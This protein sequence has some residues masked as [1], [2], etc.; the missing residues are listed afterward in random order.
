MNLASSKRQWPL[1][2]GFER[3][4]GFLGGE[5][6]QWYPDLVYDNHPGRP[7]RRSPEEGYH[8]TVDLDRQGD[9]VHPGREG[10]RAGQA[11]LP[12]LLPRR[13]ARAAPRRRRSGPTSTR[14]SSTWATRP[15]ASRSSSAR[16]SSG[17]AARGHRALADQPVRRRRRATTASPGRSST[18]CARGTRS[19]TTRSGCSRG[20]RRCTRASSSH[21]DHEIGRLLDYLEESG[22]LDNTIIVLVSDNGASGEGG[23]NGSV[24]ENK[25]FN[26]VPDTIEENLKHARRARQPEDVQPLPDRLGVGVQH[27]VQDVE[28]LRELRGRHRRPADRLLADGDQGRA[29]SCA[30]ST[31]HAIDIVPTLLRVPRRRAA[32]RRQR[33]HAEAARGRQLRA[34]A[35]TTPTRR[36]RRRR[37]STRCSARGRSGTRAGR[38][39]PRSRPRPSRGATSTSSAGS[40]STPRPTRASATTSPTQHPEKL[41]ELIALWWAEAGK[42]QALP[43]ESRGAI[44]ILGAERPQLSKPRDRYVYYPGGAEVPESVAPNIRNRSYTIAAECEIETPEAGGVIFSQG[45]RFGG[46]ALYV[47]DGKLKYVYNW[48]GE[49][50]QIVESDEPIPTGHVVLSASFEREDDAMPTQ[51]TLSLHIRDEKVGEADDHD[52]AR[53]VRARRRRPRRRTVRGRAGHR[54]LRRRARPGRS[55]AARSSASSSTSAASRSSTSPRRRGRRSRGS[56]TRMSILLAAVIVVVVAAAGH[57]G[58]AARPPARSRGQ[59]LRRRRPRRGRVRRARHR[60]SR[61]CSGF[62]VFLAFESYDTSRSRRRDRG[63]DRRAAVRDRPV[64]ARRRARRR[65]RTSSSA[66]RATVVHQEWP[67]MADGHPRRRDQPVGRRDCSGRCKAIEPQLGLRAGGLRQVARPAR[68]PREARARPHPR[69]RGR[70]PDAALDRAVPHRRRS[71]SSSCCSSPT[72]ASGSGHPGDAD[73]RRRRRDR[74]RLLLLLWFLD[75]PYHAGVGG[76][77]PVAMER[78]LELLDQQAARGRRRARIPCDAA[79]VRAW[80]TRPDCASR[81]GARDDPARR[82][83]PSGPPGR[84]T[85]R[86][87]GAASRRRPAT[88]RPPRACRRTARRRSPTARSRSRSRRSSSG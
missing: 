29:A 9:R 77:K 32:R 39:R 85:R 66:T 74:P 34:T 76:L 42:Y 35:S 78:T 54:R 33:L 62:V 40:C 22:Q 52:P 36:R 50:V 58:D 38:R 6:N 4:Y 3:F 37:S 25:F 17:I 75:N 82:W 73:G 68:R 46:H 57:R 10:D 64:P 59:L 1:G 70:H 28:A 51:G 30:A 69:R 18:G 53:Q 47:N 24:N 80:L 21:A 55:S 43:L 56:S 79:G 63:A 12:L 19:P 11:V 71:S 5:T 7:S 16:S 84:P 49:L 60:A 72:A 41:Q 83:R 2:R 31:R 48:V 27:A 14:A 23:P 86:R 45:S 81:R 20:W 67:Q 8:L 13:R 15:T 61:C 44:E 26:G 65:C 88:A 87:T